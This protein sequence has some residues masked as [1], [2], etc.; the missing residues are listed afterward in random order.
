[1]T[2]TGALRLAL[3][4]RGS[5][6][7]SPTAVLDGHRR[8][9]RGVGVLEHH[10]DRSRADLAQPRMLET[11]RSSCL[12]SKWIAAV[13][14]GNQAQQRPAQRGLAAAALTD[15]ARR[16]RRA[17]AERLTPSTALTVPEPGP[18]QPGQRPAAQLEVHGQVPDVE[19]GRGRGRSASPQASSATVE[20]LLLQAAGSRRP[21]SASR[22]PAEPALDPA[23]AVVARCRRVPWWRRRSSRRGIAGGSG[24]RPAGPPGPAVRRRCS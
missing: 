22:R 11:S 1:M 19:H 12:P 15:Q 18:E 10:L 24:T 6:A 5:P 4:C 7:R 9:E 8:V 3:A 21:G 20:L 13:G 17:S 16:P 23:A 14:R 2:L